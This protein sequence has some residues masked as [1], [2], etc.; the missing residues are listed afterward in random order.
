MLVLQSWL[1]LAAEVLP[2]LELPDEAR[3]AR[4]NEKPRHGF[5]SCYFQDLRARL[6]G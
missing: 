5:F 1:G 3:R 2:L 4:V 6:A